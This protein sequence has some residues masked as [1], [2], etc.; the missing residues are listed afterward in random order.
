ML[1][2]TTAYLMAQSYLVDWVRIAPEAASSQPHEV[3]RQAVKVLPSCS[4]V[5]SDVADF[6]PLMSI[7]HLSSRVWRQRDADRLGA[8]DTL[9]GA[10]RPLRA[11]GIRAPTETEFATCLLPGVP[12]AD[13]DSPCTS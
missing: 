5:R 6:S 10:T 7:Q 9:T 12:V 8:D 13:C 11:G 4:H 1:R 2:P 3:C